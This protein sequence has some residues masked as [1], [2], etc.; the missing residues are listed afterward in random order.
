M[1]MSGIDPVA[2]VLLIPVC[3]AVVL[4]LLPGYKITAR[5]NVV[6][7]LGSFL[8]AASLLVLPRPLPPA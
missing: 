8:C 5:L 1:T 2:G 4:A 3:A 6:A 7:S